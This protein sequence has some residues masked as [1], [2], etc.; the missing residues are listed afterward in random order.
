[1]S[2]KIRNEPLFLGLTHV[3]QVFSIGWSEKIGRCSV[4]DFDKNLVKKFEDYEVTNEEPGLKIYLKKNYQKITICKNKEDIK[5]Y[6][7][8]FLTIDTPLT[9]DGRPKVEKIISTL[10]QA[11][12]FIKKNSNLIITSQV[13]CGF[14][15]D[16]KKTI[17]K[18]RPDINLIYLAETLIMGNALDRFLFPERIILGHD[19]KIKFIKIFKKFNC[20]IYNFSLREAEMVKIA[21]NLFLFS[22][23]SYAN[24]MDYYC[25]QFGFKFS[26][27]NGALRS[28][29]RIGKLSYISPSLGVS[30]GHLERDVFTMI[31]TSKSPEVKN[32]FKNLKKV[33][34]SRMLLLIKKYE[35]LRKQFKF[36][37]IIW[38]GPSYKN[39]SFSINNSPFIKFRKYLKN[40]KKVLYSFDSYFD[41]KKEKINNF[42]DK[43]DKKIFEKSLIIFNYASKSHTKEIS[44]FLKKNICKAINL[45]FLSNKSKNLFQLF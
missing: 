2:S 4:Y 26:R 16:L 36:K 11:I 27:I 14:C 1:M 28:D 22:S 24:A 34:D 33:N 5:N 15:D 39:N 19:K 25:R 8:I 43:F 45:N 18:N 30:G 10:K 17:L 13:Y 40:R 7:T 42:L 6:N 29:K 3:G 35:D 21:I 37:K 32:L 9:L 31:K 20:Q 38:F 23:V 12:N 41:L 44:K